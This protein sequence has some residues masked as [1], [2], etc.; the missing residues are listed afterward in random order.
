[1]S[2]TAAQLR[3]DLS[4]AQI[5]QALRELRLALAMWD[6][7]V[8]IAPRVIPIP[9]NGAPIEIAPARNNRLRAFFLFTG[10]VSMEI[11]DTPHPTAT[12]IPISALTA[13]GWTDDF[14]ICHKGPWYAV[15]PAGGTAG[16]ILVVEWL[17]TENPDETP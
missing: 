1:M 5:M 6:V 7:P 10:G 14:P 16:T 9:A 11:Q 12:G 2:T 4:T 17:R 8:R 3:T 15:V 13:Q